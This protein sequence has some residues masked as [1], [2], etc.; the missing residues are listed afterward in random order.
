MPTVTVSDATY[1]LLGSKAAMNTH[2]LARLLTF[3]TAYFAR[4]PGFMVLDPTMV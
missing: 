3:N 1:E 4:C 2:G